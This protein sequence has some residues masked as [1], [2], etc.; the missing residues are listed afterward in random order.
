MFLDSRVYV[1]G[2]DLRHATRRR[3][4]MS[5]YLL[6][7]VGPCALTSRWVLTEVQRCLKVGGVPIAINL[8][9]TLENADRSNPLKLLLEDK[10]FV[11]DASNTGDDE[12][13][14]DTVAKVIDSFKATRQDLIRTRA[15]AGAVVVLLLAI[16]FAGW[17]HVVAERRA[18]RAQEQQALRFVAD[19]DRQLFSNPQQA[20][21]LAAQGVAASP[22]ETSRKTAQGAVQRALAVI[23]QRQDLQKETNW[24]SNFFQSYIAGA[25]FEADLGARY[26]RAGNLLLLTTERGS[27]GAN[28]PGDAVLLDTQTLETIPLDIGVPWG[29]LELGPGPIASFRV[30]SDVSPLKIPFVFTSGYKKVSEGILVVGDGSSEVTIVVGGADDSRWQVSGAKAQNGKVAVAPGAKISF[31]VAGA[32]H[33]LT[34]LDKGQ[35]TNRMEREGNKVEFRYKVGI[36]PRS[37]GKRRLEFVGF[38]ATRQKIYLARQYNIEIY[39]LDGTFEKEIST[40]GGCTKYPI[41]LVTGVL[42]DRLILYGDTDGALYRLDPSSERCSRLAIARPAGQSVAG[43]WF[44][45]GYKHMKDLLGQEPTL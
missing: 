15:V 18:E 11:A 6:A 23:E 4:R 27:S 19:A 40:G 25:W 32:K 2:D 8:S 41:S 30:N 33:G 35:M 34:F 29:T 26:N 21:I 43:S 16:V 5:K 36:K 17:Q 13:D 12:P 10:I 7:V 42:Q 37:R 24:G 1:A 14:R 38:S 20:V 31:E 22:S 45:A 39:G 28:P 9:R 44:S 3:I